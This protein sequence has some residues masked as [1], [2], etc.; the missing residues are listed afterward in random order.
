VLTEETASPAPNVGKAR[1]SRQKAKDP[2][3]P[4]LNTGESVKPSA[5]GGGKRKAQDADDRS[6]PPA[7]P[8]SADFVDKQ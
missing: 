4:A 5:R 6:P 2:N 8:S 3:S 1:S 7:D